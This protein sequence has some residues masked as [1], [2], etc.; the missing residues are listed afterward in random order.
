MT[1]LGKLDPAAMEA[2]VYRSLGKKSR[3]VIVGP[4][5]GLDNA[6]VST[7]AEGRMI[8]TTDPVSIIPAIG[9]DASAWL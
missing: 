1:G 6:V 4:G 8:L 5:R 3:R 9:M 7:G 2:V